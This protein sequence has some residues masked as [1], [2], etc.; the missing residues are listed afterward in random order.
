MKRL[1][2]FA[3]AALWCG[4]IFAGNRGEDTVTVMNGN[5]TEVVAFFGKNL[6]MLPEL[7]DRGSTMV[8]RNIR[9][10]RSTT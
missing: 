6:A 1:I 4:A 7:T 2:G 8:T 10:S 3:L 9:A 5:R